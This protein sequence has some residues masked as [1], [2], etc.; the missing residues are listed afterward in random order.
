MSTHYHCRHTKSWTRDVAG[1]QGGDLGLSSA[2]TSLSYSLFLSHIKGHSALCEIT[3][4]K[5][6]PN[7]DNKA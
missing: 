2:S 6:L 3:R 5:Q 1:A 4:F 7:I